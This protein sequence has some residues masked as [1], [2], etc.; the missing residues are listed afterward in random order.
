MHTLH[1]HIHHY[2]YIMRSTFRY[3]DSIQLVRVAK[4]TVLVFLFYSLCI[5]KLVVGYGRWLND[6]GKRVLINFNILVN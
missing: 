5:A 4:T 2:V 1:E 3:T 6:S